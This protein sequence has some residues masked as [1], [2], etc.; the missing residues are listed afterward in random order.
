MMMAWVRELCGLQVLH[1][2]NWLCFLSFYSN[3]YDLADEDT[4]INDVHRLKTYVSED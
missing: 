1:C 4:S 3:I 2:V